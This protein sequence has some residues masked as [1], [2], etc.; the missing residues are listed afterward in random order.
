[1][2]GNKKTAAGAAGDCVGD[3]VVLACCCPFTILHV[4]V[5]VCVKVPT[6]LAH[7]AASKRQ[8]SKQRKRKAAMP[9]F[10]LDSDAEET[11]ND[12][13]GIADSSSSTSVWER[14][15]EESDGY[16]DL[17]ATATPSL[18]SDERIAWFDYFHS[19]TSEFGVHSHSTTLKE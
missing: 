5:Q 18:D 17:Q 8:Q 7:K 10:L 15:E 13:R 3:C 9:D 1:M 19:V 11:D 12:V 6:K 16:I 2:G 14:S 4:L